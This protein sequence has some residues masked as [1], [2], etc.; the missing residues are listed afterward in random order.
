MDRCKPCGNFLG[1]S[2]RPDLNHRSFLCDK[3]VDLDQEVGEKGGGFR[4]VAL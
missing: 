4:D 2:D 3:W 1:L